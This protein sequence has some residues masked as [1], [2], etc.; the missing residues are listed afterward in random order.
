MELKTFVATALQEIV[1]G[2]REAQA[3]QYGAFVAPISLGVKGAVPEGR[4]LSHAG[5]LVV[6]VVEFDVAVTAASTGTSQG[7]GRLKIA[8]FGMGVRAGV[9]GTEQSHDETVS[10]LQF[11]VPLLMPPNEQS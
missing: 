11:S 3:S 6:T 2:I 9:E 10:R 7:G 4:G 8:A 5:R 1:E